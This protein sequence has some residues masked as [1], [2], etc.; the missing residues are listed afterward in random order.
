MNQKYL[1]W[2]YS[3][4]PELAAKELIPADSVEKI[5]N[6]YGPLRE[7]EGGRKPLAVFGLVGAILVGLGIILILA[8]NW[9]Q[10]TRLHRLLIAVGILAGAQFLA[11]YVLLRKRESTPWREG[12]ATFLMLMVGA[13][14]AL[15]GQ[16]YHLTN[17]TSAFVLTWMLLVLPL[18]YVL[19]ATI[20]ALLYMMGVTFWVSSV[21]GGDPARHFV[22]LLLGGVTP[23]YWRLLRVSREANGT[24]IFGWVL[25]LCFYITFAIAFDR[26]MGQLGML[27]F[28][29]LF[30]AAY[31]AGMLWFGSRLLHNPFRLSG[32]VGMVGVAYLLSFR[33]GLIYHS[34]WQY[35]PGEVS[36]LLGIALAAFILAV[37]AVRSRTMKEL[38]YAFTPFVVGAAYVL[39]FYFGSWTSAAIL[40][41]AYLLWLSLTAIMS[42][43]R[44]NSLLSLNSGMALL[45]AVI[46]SRF[47]DVNFSFVARGVVFV[48]LGIAFL[49][50]NLIMARRKAGGG[51]EEK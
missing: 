41:N 43:I 34:E 38:Y 22:W 45:A 24:V 46:I 26:Y 47:I 36:L 2:L 13:A 31:V 48:I 33:N 17:D 39:H 42:G 35:R 15:I 49:G 11:G 8:H 50:I 9:D 28:A 5:K 27:I 21:Y 3:E 20:P 16:T 29:V 40:M 37:M 4:L 19:Q 30:A 51:N 14:M 44:E 6:Y 1:K 18:V 32:L 12:A 23:Y 10:F 25:S 7:E